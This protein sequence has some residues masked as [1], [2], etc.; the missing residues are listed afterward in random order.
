MKNREIAGNADEMA[1]EYWKSAARERIKQ[2]DIISIL[3]ILISLPLLYLSEAS[4]IT[5]N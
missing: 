2:V 4:G 3:R 5:A 1:D